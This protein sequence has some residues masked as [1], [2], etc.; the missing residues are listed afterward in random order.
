MSLKNI[1]CLAAAA[2]LSASTAMADPELRV[3]GTDVGGNTEFLIQVKPDEQM[4]LNN[5][6][7]G[8]EGGSVGV[9]LD[10]TFDGNITAVDI[11]NDDWNATITD[12]D[13]VTVDN[14]G[15]NPFAA[16]STATDC[17]TGGMECFL[18]LGGEI[19]DPFAGDTNG[20]G[21]VDGLDFSTLAT[22]W[23]LEVDP[24][25]RTEGDFDNSGTVDG[26][27][28]STL[29]TNW[30]LENLVTVATITVEG[31][32]ATAEWGGVTR[33]D[34]V[35]GGTTAILAQGNQT[36]S[37]ASPSSASSAPEPA[38]MMMLLMSGCG[39]LF[40]RRR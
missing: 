6:N 30:Q 33:P 25:D 12:P 4:L 8:G 36:F 20:D 5:P 38:T 15:W 9:E 7:T 10:F 29:A 17:G 37:V 22:N 35:G 28:F 21:V 24:A 1:L 31:N 34:D 14:V 23:Q 18:A 11:N 27:D 2:A 26:L 16:A 32:G 3:T 13:N 40:A 39:V 19:F